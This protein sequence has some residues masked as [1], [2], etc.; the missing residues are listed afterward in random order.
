MFI[1]YKED[2]QHDISHTLFYTRTNS[3]IFKKYTAKVSVIIS[4]RQQRILFV[5]GVCCC[6]LPLT[7]YK[8]IN[9]MEPKHTELLHP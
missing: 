6:E 5:A 3:A 2:V 1:V 4:L 9:E 8:V 7:Q